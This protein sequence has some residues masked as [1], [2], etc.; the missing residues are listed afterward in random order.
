[1]APGDS[2]TLAHGMAA[3]RWLTGAE[4]ATGDGGRDEAAA[5]ERPAAVRATRLGQQGSG[6]RL[7]G[8]GATR[9]GNGRRE[10]D[11]RGGAAWLGEREACCRDGRRAVPTAP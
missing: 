11:C 7:S 4:S 2:S 9:S 6:R 10:R 3:R 5:A 8:G 1:M